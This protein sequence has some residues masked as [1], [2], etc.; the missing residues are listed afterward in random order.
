MKES[1]IAEE[2]NPSQKGRIN[3]EKR[4]HLQGE[5]ELCRNPGKPNYRRGGIP[6]RETRT[7]TKISE[8]EKTRQSFFVHSTQVECNQPL[9]MQDKY[10]LFLP[11][12]LSVDEDSWT[13]LPLEYNGTRIC[14]CLLA[15]LRSQ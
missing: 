2:G 7:R 11:D 3:T 9:L 6:H 12:R 8:I 15:T 10:P 5:R 13:A 14:Q 4:T 1:I